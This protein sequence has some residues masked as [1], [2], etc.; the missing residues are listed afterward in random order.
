MV[1]NVL[2]AV[3]QYIK[4]SKDFDEATDQM[5]RAERQ[6]DSSGK[7]RDKACEELKRAAGEATIWVTFGDNQVLAYNKNGVVIHKAEK[8][9]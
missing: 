6:Q 2:Q 8:L 9:T 5:S 7:L 4:S 1:D 3:K